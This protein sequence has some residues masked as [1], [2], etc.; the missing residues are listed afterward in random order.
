VA[1]KF[2]GWKPTE[3]STSIEAFHAFLDDWGI[4]LRP[5]NKTLRDGTAPIYTTPNQLGL[6][7][8]VTLILP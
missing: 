7:E 3:T 5:G 6:E 8:V 4:R 2:A 1:S